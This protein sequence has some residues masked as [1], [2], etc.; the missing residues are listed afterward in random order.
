MRLNK[1][2]GITILL[3][4]FVS[5][6]KDSNLIN[7]DIKEPLFYYVGYSFSGHYNE[8]DRKAILVV[9][10]SI[11]NLSPNRS[12]DAKVVYAQ[13]KDVFVAGN[14]HYEEKKIV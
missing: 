3:A 14:E 11:V 13:G 2:I 9:Q 6:K 5:C 1:I 10:D 8:R 7:D 12:A 4:I